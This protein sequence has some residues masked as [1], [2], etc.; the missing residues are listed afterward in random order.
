MSGLR[1]KLATYI[2]IKFLP[3]SKH[4]QFPLRRS[5]RESVQESSGLASL[6]V[7]TTLT[8]KNVLQSYACERV[9]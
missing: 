5:I 7:S 1:V 9:T 2:N 6:D 8:L 3:H 4:S